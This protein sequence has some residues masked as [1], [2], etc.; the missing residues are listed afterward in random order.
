MYLIASQVHPPGSEEDDRARVLLHVFFASAPHPFSRSAVGSDVQLSTGNCGQSVFLRAF[1]SFPYTAISI[2]NVKLT[3]LKETVSHFAFFK[4]LLLV[5][6]PSQ[7]PQQLMLPVCKCHY[8]QPIHPRITPQPLQRA[9]PSC[10]HFFSL[11]PSKRLLESS[12]VAVY[13]AVYAVERAQQ[14][15][16]ITDLLFQSPLQHLRCVV[17]AIKVNCRC[18]S[19]LNLQVCV[20]ICNSHAVFEYDCNQRANAF[21]SSALHVVHLIFLILTIIIYL[22]N[23]SSQSTLHQ[24]F[25][26]SCVHHIC[27]NLHRCFW[28]V[29]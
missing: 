3:L 7:H 12:L 6:H 14:P 22:P 29:R 20:F 19:Y 17:F 2:P 24:L 27:L 5:A 28:H 26:S 8:Q 25:F 23:L 21:A 4:M 13:R 10:R 16:A 1:R 15:V 11:F 9:A 18:H